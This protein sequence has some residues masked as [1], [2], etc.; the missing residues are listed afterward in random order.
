MR[1]L[2]LVSCDLK[3]F[4]SE[5]PSL[6]THEN[7]LR[8]LAY[9]RHDRECKIANVENELVEPNAGLGDEWYRQSYVPAIQELV[10]VPKEDLRDL[11]LR[12]L[13]ARTPPMELEA[14]RTRSRNKY[15]AEARKDVA[16][17]AYTAGHSVAAIAEFLG[18]SSARIS[19]M[20]SRL[21]IYSPPQVRL[22]IHTKPQGRRK[23]A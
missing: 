1:L 22:E 13:K 11:T 17:A 16:I 10:R 7:Y 19:Q 6:S 5:V 12:I 14:L 15:V 21:N 4:N 3:L 2:E 20:T 9:W 8:H 18:L 23:L